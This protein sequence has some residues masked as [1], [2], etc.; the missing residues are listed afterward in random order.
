MSTKSETRLQ[1]WENMKAEELW[2]VLKKTYNLAK[3]YFPR[4]TF[5]I[6]NLITC[7]GIYSVA[8]AMGAIPEPL[9]AYTNLGYFTALGIGITKIKI[10]HNKDKLDL[11]LDDILYS[12]INNSKTNS[13]RI[14]LEFKDPRVSNPFK[15]YLE[16]EIK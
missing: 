12:G 6:Q 8:Y 5:D 7:S 10:D 4:T 2:M 15:E 1:G 13:K 16:V 14:N 9:K 3:A 11:K